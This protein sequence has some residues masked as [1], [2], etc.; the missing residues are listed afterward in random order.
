MMDIRG[1]EVGGELVENG[2]ILAGEDS[3]AQ[4]QL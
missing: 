1:V 2:A 3:D 4:A